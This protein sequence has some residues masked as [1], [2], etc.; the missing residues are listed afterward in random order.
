VKTPLGADLII[1]ALALA[2]AGYFFFSIADLAWEAKANGVVIGAILVLLIA[3]QL[4]RIGRR[5]YRGEGDLR[6]DPVWQPADALPRRI[7]MV[8]ITIAF[9]ATLQWL[10]VT[11]G[12]LLALLAALWIMGV[13]NRRALILVPLV[14]AAAMYLLFIVLLQS[15]IPHGPIEKLLS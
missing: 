5:L 1:P 9:I 10:G 2:F 15:D 3:G 8:L 12:L 6:T 13:R 14:V 11:L 7:G 4:A